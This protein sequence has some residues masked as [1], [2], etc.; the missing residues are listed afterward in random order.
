MTEPDAVRDQ[1]V[2]D[3]YAPPDAD[4]P[5]KGYLVAMGVYTALTGTAVLVARR[6]KRRL[7]SLSMSDLAL[8]GMATHRASRLLAKDAVTSPLRASF[9]RFEEPG[10]PGELNEAVRADSEVGHAVGELLTCPFCIG[11]W[12]A[13]AFVAGTV[14]APRATKLAA[15]VFAVAGVAD[16][17]QFAYAGAG[18]LDK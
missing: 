15:G 16:F 10:A 9:T 1:A 6:Q 7:P 2:P 12:I 14:F 8:Y 13:T 4:R 18:K 11:Q 3:A 5:L 17:L